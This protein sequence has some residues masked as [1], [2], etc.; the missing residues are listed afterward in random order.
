[1]TD[2]SSEH[3][4]SWARGNQSPENASIA[5]LADTPMKG[6][7][8]PARIAPPSPPENGASRLA[9][10]FKSGN[11]SHPKTPEDGSFERRTTRLSKSSSKHLKQSRHS[12]K[13]EHEDDTKAIPNALRVS[14]PSQMH[15]FS[16]GHEP[17]SGSGASSSGTTSRQ[18]SSRP[19]RI[20]E[21]SGSS[22]QAYSSPQ[23][24]QSPTS[25]HN[26]RGS[27]QGRPRRA[28]SPTL[29][30]NGVTYATRLREIRAQSRTSNVQPPFSTTD[31]SSGPSGLRRSTTNSASISEE[32]SIALSISENGASSRPGPISPSGAVSHKN[33]SSFQARPKPPVPSKKPFLMK[34]S[35][36]ARTDD[37]L[38]LE[39]ISPTTNTSSSNPPNH[40]TVPP[41]PKQRHRG[42]SVFQDGMNR[43][44]VDSFL[45]LDTD[46]RPP[47]QA[48]TAQRNANGQTLYMHGNVPLNIPAPAGSPTVTYRE[49]MSEEEALKLAIAESLKSY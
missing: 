29:D 6:T 2:T 46:V 48:N 5:E 40:P 8:A 14:Q 10:L 26:S 4:P 36:V 39:N 47:F 13:L 3:I 32:Q 34:K 16:N 17:E 49:D 11:N 24:T 18:R 45:G 22:Y 20:T 44:T 31:S 35:T 15:S 25:G 28:T 42:S 30:Q 9:G 1:M 21:N 23:E 41:R 12:L 43:Q 33:N 19:H 38:F 37:E 7:P 27:A